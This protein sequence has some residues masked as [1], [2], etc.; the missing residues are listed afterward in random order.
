MKLLPPR[1][2][3]RKYPANEGQPPAATTLRARANSAAGKRADMPQ[4][5][6]ASV[7][8]E[9]ADAFTPYL[10]SFSTQAY[11]C[12]RERN[13]ASMASIYIPPL[14]PAPRGICAEN[15][16]DTAGAAYISTVYEF[17]RARGAGK[18]VLMIYFDNAATGGRKPDSVVRAVAACLAGI[19]ANPGRSG[20]AP[21]LAAAENIYRCRRLLCRFFG[22]EDAER[23]ILTKNCTEALN[24]A[25][26]GAARASRH[27]KPHIV[28]TAA[29]HNSVLRPLFALE[30]AGEIE[31]TVLPL[32][33]GRILPEA[34]A[35]A[36]RENT[37]AAAFTLASNVTGTEIDP[38]AV[39]AA[40]PAHVLTVC[41]GAQA[42]G[43]IPIDMKKSGIDAL[44][45][46]GHKGMCGIQG[47]GALLLSARFSP[48]PLLYGGS[49]SAS[50]D[51][52]MPAFYPDRLEA[53]TLSCPAAASLAEGVLYLTP[54]LAGIGEKLTKLTALLAAELAKIPGISAYSLPNRCGIF[55][56][57]SA[58]MSSELLAQE[59]SD[60]YGI[61]VRGGLHCAPLMHRA[62]GTQKRGLVRAS[63]S[64]Y[65][66]EEEVLAFARAVREITE[67]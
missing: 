45:V 2:T 56:F 29:E 28:T 46:A 64:G 49:G 1:T 58:K 31:L 13:T 21:A 39:R 63:L 43:H 48:P 47:S 15:A 18:E 55:A 38:A 32:A 62:L 35:A 60:G 65:D 9:T 24:I 27:K 23:V 25:L 67:A 3:T 26:F 50:A 14:L 30:R 11:A 41:D 54:R 34:F 40:L 5:T 53:G 4:P 19:C 33:Q 6:F 22:A 59:L 8:V 66:T 51:P 16:Q 37:A 44:C 12:G 10:L 42:C 36:C 7:G 57:E 52:D 17:F 61:A 20:H